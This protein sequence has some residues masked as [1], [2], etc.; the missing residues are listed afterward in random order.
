MVSHG[1]I[2]TGQ[3]QQA[4]AQ[5]TRFAR[6]W[7][8]SGTVW[9]GRFESMVAQRHWAEALDFLDRTADRPSLPAEWIEHWVEMLTALKSHDASALQALRQKSVAPNGGSPQSAIL[10]LALM[11]F[12][13]DAFS[14]AARYSPAAS[15]EPDFLFGPPLAA[16][17]LDPR[18][19]AL[20]AKF[21]LPEYWRRTG[22]WADFCGQPNLP[23]DCKK[24]AAKLLGWHE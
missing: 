3:S 21:R 20:A 16:L 15:D 22:V 10:S 11:G 4:D 9:N 19:M 7:P 1:L 17:R 2:W 12:I 23:Y 8:A 24:E 6:L 5:L 18:F 13:D 14:V